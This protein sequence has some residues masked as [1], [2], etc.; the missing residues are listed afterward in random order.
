MRE[1]NVS[2]GGD[3]FAYLFRKMD[4]HHS[5]K[6]KKISIGGKSTNSRAEQLFFFFEKLNIKQNILLLFVSLM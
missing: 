4:S 6:E 5:Q 3:H 1:L 2:I